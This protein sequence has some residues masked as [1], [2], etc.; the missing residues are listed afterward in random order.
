M[1]IKYLCAKIANNKAF[2]LC[3]TAIIL[4][5][6]L[7]IGVETYTSNETIRLIQQSILYVFTFEILI[8]FIAAKSLKS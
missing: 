1:R 7:L 2:E 3:I 8:R 5:N 6:S 4:I